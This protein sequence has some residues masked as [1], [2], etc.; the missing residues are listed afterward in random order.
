MA[1]PGIA[2][3][4]V[5]MNSQEVLRSNLDILNNGLSDLEKQVLQEINTQY[6][7]NVLSIHQ[8]ILSI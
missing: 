7:I 8:C 3:N 4:L 1:Q 5:G 6:V 2:T